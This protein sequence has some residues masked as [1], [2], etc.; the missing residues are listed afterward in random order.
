[1][2]ANEGGLGRERRFHPHTNFLQ[3]CQRPDNDG[4]SWNASASTTM[5]IPSP[6]KS[7]EG[8]SET[9]GPT[10]GNREETLNASFSLVVALPSIVTSFSMVQDKSGEIHPAESNNSLNQSVSDIHA[11]PSPRSFVSF[12]E[13]PFGHK[14]PVQL[15]PPPHGANWK[16]LEDSVRILHSPPKNFSIFME[17]SSFTVAPNTMRNT[18]PIWGHVTNLPKPPDW[19]SLDLEK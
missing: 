2:W 13:A 5:T 11:L 16:N 6:V 14:V 7:F 4:D 19:R 1:M 10:E 18:P 9:G 15:E 17:M 8:S 3:A 12:D